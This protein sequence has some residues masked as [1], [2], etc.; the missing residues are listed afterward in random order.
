MPE[1]I[2]KCQVCG[3]H[4]PFSCEIGYEGNVTC[5]SCHEVRPFSEC[6]VMALCPHCK[7]KLAVPSDILGD[8][9]IQCPMCHRDFNY[10]GMEQGSVLLQGT[11]LTALPKDEPAEKQSMLK[12]GSFIN[13]YRIERLL[14]S[15]GMA[16]VYLATHL[17][18][19]KMFALKVMRPSIYSDNP[20]LA[21][22][23]LREAQ[24][25][26]KVEHPNIVTVSDAGV[27]KENGLLFLVMEYV[28]GENL[29]DFA[30]GKRLPE[31]L[32]IHVA[33]KVALALQA[34][35]ANSIVHRDIKPSNIML[36]K[37]GTIKLMDLGIAKATEPV[38]EE[39]EVTLTMEQSVLGTPA[40]ASPEQCRAAHSVD[41]RS[42]IYSLGASLYHMATGHPPFGGTTAL[43]VLFKVIEK[44]P[45]PLAKERPDL[46]PA[47]TSLV[48][49]MME[50]DPAK[51][52][53]TPEELLKAIEAGTNLHW[54]KRMKWGAVATA[55][56]VPLI[57]IIWFF[58]GRTST[59]KS[60]F[61][62]KTTSSVEEPASTTETKSEEKAASREAGDGIATAAPTASPATTTEAKLEEKAA[63][64][65]AGDGLA[66]TA[67]KAASRDAGDGLAT[68]ASTAAPA[69][70]EAQ[71]SAS[72]KS[73]NKALREGAENEALI[74]KMLSSN[75]PVSDIDF[76]ALAEAMVASQ[77]PRVY[78]KTF[79]NRLSSRLLSL[80]EKEDWEQ[81]YKLFE[82][83]GV[84]NDPSLDEI[85]SNEVWQKMVMRLQEYDRQGGLSSPK[86]RE[87]TKIM[88]QIHPD[89]PLL[90]SVDSNEKIRRLVLRGNFEA[91][92]SLINSLPDKQ[93]Q[94]QRQALEA[95]KR[96]RL[97]LLGSMSRSPM[98][99]NYP[100][101]A[102][103]ISGELK[104]TFSGDAY[105]SQRRMI[106]GPLAAMQ[107]PEQN[108]R[109]RRSADA[110]PP[111]PI[112]P[113]LMRACMM[114]V[115]PEVIRF[116]EAGADYHA[117]YQTSNPDSTVFLRVLTSARNMSIHR[118]VYTVECIV[119]ILDRGLKPTPKELELIKQFPELQE[120]IP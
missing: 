103:F 48:E 53:Q 1:H 94:S 28:E 105:A 27:D 80:I 31:S 49:R 35:H 62:P 51:R 101:L 43:E 63:S 58:S 67:E 87:L 61:P 70:E 44:S 13:N 111:K 57:G 10:E 20:V 92:E 33:E 98:A 39:K 112:P 38:G 91:A 4:F 50:K 95:E 5:P 64:R 109:P 56:L 99:R 60:V 41:I 73:E 102:D 54:R 75:T 6:D 19:N 52:P 22:R 107:S 25:A 78:M 29:A 116:L 113:V 66:T 42:D 21:K 34:M 120:F 114:G 104:R 83:V 15:G 82:D 86:A 90:S 46:S 32:L 115:K 85:W 36:C 7:A 18:L 108:G 9:A 23:F 74:R 118:R 65:E 117:L 96:R 26:F 24:L 72:P 76:K 119:E 69:R 68:S 37:D 17:L 84:L 77:N 55:I 110:I 79:N 2:I 89:D 106:E 100:A 71:A 12:P 93:R 47:F 16:E 45:V 8:S 3:E 81:A 59:P 14:G 40:Y 30:N 97:D 11:T 88:K